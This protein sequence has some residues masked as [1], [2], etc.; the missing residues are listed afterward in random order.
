MTWHKTSLNVCAANVIQTKRQKKH[1]KHMTNKSFAQILLISY[2]IHPL[3]LTI[4]FQTNILSFEQIVQFKNV[5]ARP[6]ASS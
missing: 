5:R 4:T 3:K 1:L 6:H 2:V